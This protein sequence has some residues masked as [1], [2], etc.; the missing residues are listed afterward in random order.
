VRRDPETRLIFVGDASMAP[1]ELPEVNGSIAVKYR[2]HQP[3]IDRLKLLAATFR[4]AVWFNPI[5]ASLCDH[6]ETI[7]LI[8][9]ILPMFELNLTGLEKAG[10][11]PLCSW[12]LCVR[13]FRFQA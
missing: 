8:R 3:G 5:P 4:H 11:F 13:S 7:S 12:C 1:E 6:G 9:T 2:R 10:S